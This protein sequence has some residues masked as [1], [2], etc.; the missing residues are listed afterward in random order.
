MPIRHRAVFTAV[1]F[2]RLLPRNLPGK[3]MCNFIDPLGMGRG[4]GHSTQS[5]RAMSILPLTKHTN[6]FVNG[7]WTPCAGCDE[8]KSYNYLFR[9]GD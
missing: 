1:M 2:E 9:D 8:E 7:A 3:V 4:I 6:H 5:P